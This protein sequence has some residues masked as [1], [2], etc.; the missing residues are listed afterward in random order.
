M[1]KKSAIVLAVLYT[2]ALTAACLM[3]LK[4]MPKVDVSNGDKIFHFGAYAAFTV[5]WYA[6]FIFNF[7]LEQMKALLYATVFAVVFGIVIEVLQDTMTDYRA[8]DIY[9]VVANSLGALL[10]ALILWRINKLQVK[11]Q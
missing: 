11:K 8:M 9:D 10:T 7:K 3:S 4:D 1:L 2:V 6:A 5:L